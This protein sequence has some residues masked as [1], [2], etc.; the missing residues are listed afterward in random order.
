MSL[1]IG[2]IGSHIVT[3]VVFGTIIID[4]RS[5]ID[6]GYIFRTIHIISS[7]IVVPHI[8]ARHECPIT[9]RK[10]IDCQPD[11]VVHSGH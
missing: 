1:Y 7:N 8:P 5:I 11:I 9:R 10:Q 3:S 2:G 4:D 6:D